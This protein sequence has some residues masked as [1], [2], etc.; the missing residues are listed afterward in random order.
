MLRTNCSKNCEKCNISDLAC[1]VIAVPIFTSDVLLGNE[2][3][4]FRFP[5]ACAEHFWEDAINLADEP[6]PKCDK[7][8]PTRTLYVR[9]GRNLD[10]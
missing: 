1:Q 4:G 5:E 10:G 2:Q 7:C 6:V 3:L 9:T 8:W